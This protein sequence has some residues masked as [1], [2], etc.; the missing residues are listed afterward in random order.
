[1]YA[2]RTPIELREGL[3]NPVL[4]TNKSRLV[5]LIEFNGF[6]F[7]VRHIGYYYNNNYNID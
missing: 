1:M 3:K 2:C 4:E 7:F 6:S 5:S